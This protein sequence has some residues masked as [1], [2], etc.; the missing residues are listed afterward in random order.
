MDMRRDRSSTCD[1]SD[2]VRAVSQ[3]EAASQARRSGGFEMC[4]YMYILGYMY[5]YTFILQVVAISLRVAPRWLDIAGA[6]VAQLVPYQ[7]AAWLRG[8]LGYSRRVEHYH[9]TFKDNALYP[10]L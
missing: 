2:G 5:M 8:R 4:M 3:E 6:H 9:D 10:W 7:P 1:S